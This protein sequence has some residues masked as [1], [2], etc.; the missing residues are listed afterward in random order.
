MVDHCLSGSETHGVPDTISHGPEERPAARRRWLVPAGVLVVATAMLAGLAVHHRSSGASA[1][2]DQVPPEQ[3]VALALP[4][5][6]AFGHTVDLRDGASGQ[7]PWTVVVR[8]R[9]GSLGQHG[10][11]VT[12]PVPARTAGTAVRVGAIAGRAGRHTISWP[13][14]GKHARIRGDLDRAELLA[15][16]GRT[17]VVDGRPRVRAPAGFAVVAGGPYRSRHVREVQYGQAELVAAGRLDGTVVTGVARGGGFEDRLYATGVTD[18]L[19]VHGRPAVVSRVG[20]GSGTLAWE[21]V[22]GVVAFV[23][24]AGVP[25]DG[26][27]RALLHQL[28]RR[29]VPIGRDRWL[30]THPKI[31]AGPGGFG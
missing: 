16:A 11:V 31:L 4:R 18:R 17:S 7:G 21:P 13:I 28:A 25:L 26:M 1:P 15:L 23:G 9:G 22:P 12:Y 19:R 20:A 5:A 29:A 6:D 2:P 30:A 10:A 27:A 14:G 8:R 3:M 24:Y